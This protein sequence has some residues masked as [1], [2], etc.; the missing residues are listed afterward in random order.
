VL[1]GVRGKNGFFL[2]NSPDSTLSKAGFEY[3]VFLQKRLD[4][5]MKGRTK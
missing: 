5:L 4:N 1:R 2:S 3:H